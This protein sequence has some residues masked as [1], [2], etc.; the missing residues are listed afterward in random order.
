MSQ[1]LVPGPP[2]EKQTKPLLMQ[3]YLRVSTDD[4][5]QDP[6]RQSDLIQAWATRERVRLMPPIEDNISAD[7]TDPFER[8]AFMHA[9]EEARDK[10]ADGILIETTDRL[11]RRGMAHFF[12]CQ[13]RLKTDHRLNVYVSDQGLEQQASMGGEIVLAIQ[14]AMAQ[15]WM[16]R[17]KRAV[18]SGMDRARLNGSKFGRK[19]KQFTEDE[20]TYIKTE[21]AKPAMIPHKNK[22]GLTRNPEKLGYKTIAHEINRRRGCFELVDDRSRKS[23]MISE[24]TIRRIHKAVKDSQPDT[25][26]ARLETPPVV[27]ISIADAAGVGS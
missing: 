20:M 8:D 3:P 10:G 17:H 6:K 24:M 14:A 23:K 7:K 5:G 26:K 27:Q 19:P 25:S 12:V 13:Y 18:K 11:T 22:Q 2:P 16:E 1:I 21:L 15:Q 9:I 4:K